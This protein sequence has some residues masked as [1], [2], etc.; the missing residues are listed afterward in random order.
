MEQIC[1]LG[2]SVH[3]PMIID[4]ND[5]QEHQHETIL[6]ENDKSSDY[7][8]KAL[9]LFD[10]SLLSTKSIIKKQCSS[11]ENSCSST[12]PHR[13]RLDRQCK[14]NAEKNKAATRVIP[15]QKQKRL[16]RLQELDHNAKQIQVIFDKIEVTKGILK[17]SAEISDSRP[18]R[19]RRVKFDET[20][21]ITQKK[22][23]KPKATRKKNAKVSQKKNATEIVKRKS[24]GRKARQ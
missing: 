4:N 23:Q 5:I 16:N 6:N 8:L 22:V 10:L 12:N 1:D 24:A 14:I 15:T 17:A 13:K 2:I 18:R 3:E 7:E 21:M 9:F 20:S 19:R 11:I